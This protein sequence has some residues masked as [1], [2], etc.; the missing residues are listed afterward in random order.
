MKWWT[1]SPGIADT[2]LVNYRCDNASEGKQ[3]WAAFSR[4][5][6][7]LNR[8]ACECEYKIGIASNLAERWL[9]YQ[10]AEPGKWKPSHLFILLEV[11]DR[12][13]AGFAEAGLIGMSTAT[14]AFQEHKNINVLNS[15]LGGTGPRKD[16]PYFVY[17]AVKK[18]EQ[19]N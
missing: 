14:K 9:L 11:P 19:V 16:S 12:C 15:D 17:L 3:L 6:Y 2:R 13:S 7:V 10:A 18:F 4:L 8:T 5:R 1:W